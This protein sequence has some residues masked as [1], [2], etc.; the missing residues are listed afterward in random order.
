[1]CTIDP[2]TTLVFGGFTQRQSQLITLSGEVRVNLV[3][4]SKYYSL[5][6]IVARKIAV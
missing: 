2:K 3:T 5:S 6:R 1:M 4:M